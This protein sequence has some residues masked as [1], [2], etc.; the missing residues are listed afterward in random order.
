MSRPYKLNQTPTAPFNL[1]ELGP[2]KLAE[3]NRRIAGTYRTAR[4]AKPDGRATV[5]P[6]PCPHCGSLV[7]W[8]A[9]SKR[10]AKG[11]NVRY[12]YARCRANR[13]HRWSFDGPTLISNMDERR[14][15]PPTP[16]VARPSAGSAMSAWIADRKTVLEAELMKLSQIETLAQEVGAVRPRPTRVKAPEGDV[17]PN[18]TPPGAQHSAHVR[19]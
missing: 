6:S 11:E 17:A 14:V 8:S 1:R 15:T 13:N 2:M 10:G 7:E 9:T 18:G 4:G 3:V 16:P 5:D 19:S 12:I